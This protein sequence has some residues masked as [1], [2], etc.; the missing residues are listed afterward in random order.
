MIMNA[1]LTPDFSL[2]KRQSLPEELAEVIIRRIEAGEFKPGDVLPPEQALADTFKVSRTVVREAL[3]RLKY[4]GLIQSK[5]GSGPIVCKAAAPRNFSLNLESLSQDEW[6]RFIEFRIVMEGEAAAMAAV[7]RSPQQLGQLAV[8]LDQMRQAIEDN[9]SGTEP[10]YL[11]HCLIADSGGNEYLGE[12]AKF[13]SAKI[14]LGV[15]RARWLSNQV[16][17]QADL[18]LEEHRATYLAIEAADPQKA[19]E[20]AQRHLFNSAARQGLTV[21]KRFLCHNLASS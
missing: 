7:R 10:D 4:E 5:R 11:F 6:L 13:I 20:A 3:A 15:Y 18:V 17:D 19:R 14:W 21:D 16:R 12:F 9:N 8:Y 2:R 1:A